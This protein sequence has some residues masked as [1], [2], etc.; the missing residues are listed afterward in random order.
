[1]DALAQKGNPQAIEFPRPMIHNT[2]FSA[3]GG[4]PPKDGQAAYGGNF[5]FSGLKTAALYFMKTLKHPPSPKASDGRSKNTKSQLPD[6][7]ASVQ[8][9]IVDVLVAKTVRAAERYKVK[10][11]MLGGGVAANSALRVQLHKALKVSWPVASFHVPITQ[12]C[13]DN[14]AMIA[15]AGFFQIQKQWGMLSAKERLK[16]YSWKKLFVNPNWNI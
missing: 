2:D 7:C 4:S 16:R 10:T 1:M 14:A 12:Y 13:T 5:S 8:Q 6:I 15:A 3:K 9:A 11:V